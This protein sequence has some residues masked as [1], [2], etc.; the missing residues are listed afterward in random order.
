MVI[1]AAAFVEILCQ[2]PGYELVA[3]RVRFKSRRLTDAIALYE[4]VL[5]LA[6]IRAVS[7]D[8]A[9]AVVEGFRMPTAIVVVTLGLREARIALA[10]HARFGKSRHPARLN[11]G[12]C[13]AYACAKAKGARLLFVGDDFPQTDIAPAL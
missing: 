7:V 10:A 2:E 12:H 5:A 9:E 1:D 8:A 6:R 4:A 13:F 11:R 3:A